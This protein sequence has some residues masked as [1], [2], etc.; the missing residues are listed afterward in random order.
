MSATMTVDSTKLNLALNDWIKATKQDASEVIRT[1]S[2]LFAGQAMRLT[3]PKRKAQGNKTV[4]N[5][6][7]KIV[8]VASEGLIRRVIENTGSGDEKKTWL[9]RKD[10]TPYL[11]EWERAQLNDSGL[12]EFHRKSR[13]K[14]GRVSTA[15]DRTR[16]IGRWVA[17]DK[18]VVPEKVRKSYIRKVQRNVGRLKAGWLPTLARFPSVGGRKPA[19][20]I[21]DHN[22]GARGSASIIGAGSPKVFSVM[23]N[24]AEGSGSSQMGHIVRSTLKAR[25]NAITRHLK[26]HNSGYSK[27]MAAGMRMRSRAKRVKLTTRGTDPRS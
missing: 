2:R 3:P 1:E 14:N 15:G 20:W 19:K 18:M 17:R 27:D 4:K 23:I 25:L 11:I 8:D 24:N 5:D 21:T 13:T 22:S 26:L 16:N 10:G 9:A 12:K 7:M 6:I